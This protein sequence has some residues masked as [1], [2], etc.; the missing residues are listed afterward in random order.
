MVCDRDEVSSQ[1]KIV[2]HGE[3]GKKKGMMYPFFPNSPW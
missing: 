2:N 1:E 3:A